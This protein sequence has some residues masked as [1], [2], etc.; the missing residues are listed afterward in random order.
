MLEHLEVHHQC[1]WCNAW[2]DQVQNSRY[3]RPPCCI[4]DWAKLEVLSSNCSSIVHQNG[5][6]LPSSE[7]WGFCGVETSL[8]SSAFSFLRGTDW[9]ILLWDLEPCISMDDEVRED[10]LAWQR[11]SGWCFIFGDLTASGIGTRTGVYGGGRQVHQH[12]TEVVHLEED[13]PAELFRVNIARRYKSFGF[14]F[15]SAGQPRLEVQCLPEWLSRQLCCLH[16]VRAHPWFL[17]L[18][19]LGY[20]PSSLTC[21]MGEGRLRFY[22]AAYPI[23]GSCDSSISSWGQSKLR[24]VLPKR[25]CVQ[26]TGSKHLAGKE[27]MQASSGLNARAQGQDCNGL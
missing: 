5:T 21:L 12:I 14:T 18:S 22:P 25:S 15:F 20:A 8:V 26:G 3:L 13:L 17:C 7:F 6:S 1:K 16:F 4:C 11:Q 2:V 23:A 24:H 19:Q 9:M 27:I 10:C